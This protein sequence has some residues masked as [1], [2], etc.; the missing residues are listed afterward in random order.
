[1]QNLHA[2]FE[3]N[4]QTAFSTYLK[5][6]E[7]KIILVSSFRREDVT[8]M[9]LIP[10]ANIREA[11]SMSKDFLDGNDFTYIIPDGT[12]TLPIYESK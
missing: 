7:V 3:I 1:L 9:N 11:L 5:A 4:G 6:K 12:R 10:A 8:I 2:A